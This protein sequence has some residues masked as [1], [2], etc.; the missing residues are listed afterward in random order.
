MTIANELSE[1]IDKSDDALERAAFEVFAAVHKVPLIKDD[2]GY[3]F[4]GVQFAWQAWQAGTAPLLAR[5]AE[6]EKD[7]ARYQWLRDET[8]QI[9]E[10]DINVSD[11]FFIAYFGDELDIAVDKLISRRNAIE[12]EK[13]ATL[14]DTK[15]ERSWKIPLPKATPA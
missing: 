13:G 14:M 10:D 2:A 3:V 6:L 4:E 11:S 7:S 8:K 15:R 1:L 9:T 5:I 12:R